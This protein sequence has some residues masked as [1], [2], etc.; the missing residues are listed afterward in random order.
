MTLQNV[1]ITLLILIYGGGLGGR[2]LSTRASGGKGRKKVAATAAGMLGLA[3]V[4]A[5]ERVLPFS[6]RESVSSYDLWSQ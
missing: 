2:G 6:T 3:W 4:L 5:D 1:V